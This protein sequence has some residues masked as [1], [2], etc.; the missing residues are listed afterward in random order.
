ME[1]NPGILGIVNITSDSFSDGGLYLDAARAIAHARQLKADGA[2]IIDLGAASSHPDAEQVSPAEEIHRLTPV[3]DALLLRNSDK[4]NDTATVHSGGQH[5]HVSISIDS[6]QSEVQRFVLN[7]PIDFLN[8]IQG[9]SDPDMYD[10]L[11]EADCRLIVMHS[12]Q[13]KG[14]ATREERSPQA[15]LDNVYT[16]FRTRIEKLQEA[17]VD[18]RRLILDPGMGFFLGSNPHASVRALQELPRLKKEFQLPLLV[19]VS[20]KSFLGGLTGRAVQERG[21]TTLIAELFAYMQGVDFI[22]T[23]DVQSLKDAIG[24]WKVLHD[25]DCSG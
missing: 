15:V 11:A 4:L 2:E 9:F 7:Y 25:D 13:N 20:R 10:S 18:R 12:I 14:R 1:S 19:S 23:H 16:F 24:L 21:P 8:D 5:Q 17:G 3:L 6:Y 22:R